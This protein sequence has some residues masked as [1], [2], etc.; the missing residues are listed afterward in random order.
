MTLRPAR[1]LRGPSLSSSEVAG[2]L[3]VR[4]GSPLPWRL[5]K[6][7]DQ[8]NR[9]IFESM[10]MFMY[11]MYVITMTELGF[12]PIANVSDP[13]WARLVG[14]WFFPSSNLLI[15]MSPSYKYVSQ[16]SPHNRTD[17]NTQN[18]RTSVIC[19]NSLIVVIVAF[20][21]RHKSLYL[22]S[23]Y[24]EQETYTL[25]NRLMMYSFGKCVKIRSHWLAGANLNP[26]VIL[27][28]S[29][30]V[31]NWLYLCSTTNSIDY[32]ECRF[33]NG[34]NE[35]M[36]SHWY[37]GLALGLAFSMKA[38]LDGLESLSSDGSMSGRPCLKATGSLAEERTCK[39]K[40][41]L[42]IQDKSLIKK[43]WLI[44]A[45]EVTAWLSISCMVFFVLTVREII[46]VLVKT[47]HSTLSKTS[48]V[49]GHL[50]EMLEPGRV[51]GSHNEV[52]ISKNLDWIVSPTRKSNTL[53][54]QTGKI[55]P[56]SL[57]VG[58][59]S[60]D[61]GSGPE[62]LELD[63]DLDE[64]SIDVDRLH[65]EALNDE[66]R[67]ILEI[68]NNDDSPEMGVDPRVIAEMGLLGL[69][70]G[71]IP[72]RGVDHWSWNYLNNPNLEGL[73][74]TVGE[75]SSHPPIEVLLSSLM[76]Q[77]SGTS[78]SI[79]SQNLH[80]PIQISRGFDNELESLAESVFDPPAF[81]LG[82]S[83]S[84][85]SGLDGRM[86]NLP[87]YNLNAD[88]IDS[89]QLDYT[90]WLDIYAPGHVIWEEE[91]ANASDQGSN[92][93]PDG[94]YG[95]LHSPSPIQTPDFPPFIPSPPEPS[96]DVTSRT[97][98]SP[99]FLHLEGCECNGCTR[100]SPQE[101]GLTNRL[102]FPVDAEEVS[103]RLKGVIEKELLEVDI[104]KVHRENDIEMREIIKEHQFREQYRLS[105]LAEIDELE[106]EF[107]PTSES[108]TTVDIDEVHRLAYLE[109]EE[110][111]RD[112][113]KQ[114]VNPE[115]QENLEALDMHLTDIDSIHANAEADE[116]YTRQQFWKWSRSKDTATM[117]ARCKEEHEAERLE[118][119]E[120][121]HEIQRNKPPAS[122]YQGKLHGPLDKGS[123]K[124]P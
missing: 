64:P 103:A 37:S 76:E 110:V 39:R 52:T 4:D 60:I 41:E 61:L 24:S 97:E 96:Q 81:W 120:L 121:E 90:N 2:D 98:G 22:E 123:H 1:N 6:A 50:N 15:S 16:S 75:S 42:E 80:T 91:E 65:E 17:I 85:D 53:A 117:V 77:N 83:A 40:R 66:I 10:P 46:I 11:H 100:F 34:Y 87:V 105:R 35:R 114:D 3:G 31:H 36:L 122:T 78:E 88:S 19:D 28:T 47:S 93:G 18:T 12:S 9:C 44:D 27:V 20:I 116:D 58:T 71:N 21:S 62:D 51:G 74:E 95:W 111:I 70:Q 5:K 86:V 109:E 79:V 82:A 63:V 7:L 13:I 115:L 92:Y 8:S 48:L 30:R 99:I 94:Y 25:Q 29:S 33:R 43:I 32:A 84:T 104:S 56:P 57:Y 118:N 89:D 124:P 73:L 14:Y 55:V 26:W 101:E 23:M 106:Q 49:K 38:T 102:S 113:L 108:L 45:V 68:E 54:T 69:E 119:Q 107:P 59:L 67:I 72:S 112:H